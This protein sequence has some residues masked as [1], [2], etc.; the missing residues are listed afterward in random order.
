MTTTKLTAADLIVAVYRHRHGLAPTS[1]FIP[2]TKF[3]DWNIETDL[4]EVNKRGFVTEFEIKISRSDLYREYK[5]SRWRK[6]CKFHR[7]FFVIPHA[8][9][10]D[11]RGNDHTDKILEYIHPNHGL[12]T[13]DELG[14]VK[15]FRTDDGG[16]KFL[17]NAKFDDRIEKLDLA[18][19][20]MIRCYKRI[21]YKFWN[22]NI[23]YQAA[24]RILSTSRPG[25][26][27]SPDYS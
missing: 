3:H 23:D 4:L 24:K 9:L 20:D 17:R 1:F 19:R 27:I 10:T 25:T 22:I 8:I 15:R 11:K 12:I 7:Y 16:F 14:V 6:F 21:G 2:N 26:H 18:G 13:V 5:K